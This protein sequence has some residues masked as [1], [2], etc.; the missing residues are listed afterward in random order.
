MKMKTKNK[1]ILFLLCL[2]NLITVSCQS[3]SEKINLNI[4]DQPSQN[5]IS[6]NQF[7]PLRYHNF[8]DTLHTR[9]VLKDNQIDSKW[10]PFNNEGFMLDYM[11][12]YFNKEKIIG[13][14]GYLQAKS[15]NNSDEIYKNLCKSIS[16]DKNFKQIDLIH[17]DKSIL[18]S[19]WESS[20]IIIGAQYEKPN[21]SIALIAIYKNELPSFYDKIFQ[22][23]FLNLT[24]F[25]D[26]NSQIKFKELKAQPSKSDRD[27]YKDKFKE[28]KREYNKK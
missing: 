16:S 3:K 21:N 13:F 22:S 25:R 27:F 14:K 19:E 20:T 24:E 10:Q 17:N 5:I 26:K 28:L 23:E 11:D 7:Y 6:D 12:V 18:Y 8:V 4:L 15:K 9:V 1:S 2:I